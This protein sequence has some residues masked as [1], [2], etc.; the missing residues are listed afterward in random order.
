MKPIQNQTERPG[1]ELLSRAFAG[2]F[3]AFLGL[4]LLKFGNPAVFGNL[5]GW[6]ADV[7]EWVLNP[8]PVVVGYWLLGA[9]AAFG[10]LVARWRRRGPAWLI[11]LPL[12]WLAWQF[13]AGTRTVDAGLTRPV[14]Q[15]FAACVVCYYLGLLSLSRVANP[16]LFW[17]GLLCG[18]LVVLGVGFHQHFGGLEETRKFFY[19]NIYPQLKEISPEYLRKIS[20][21]RIFSTLFYPNVLAGV[22]LLLLPLMLAFVSVNRRM[23]TVPAR[24][25]SATLVGFAALACL[26]W[27][28]SKGGW[29]LML[30]AGLIWLFHLRFSRKLKLVLAGV[31]LVTGLAGFFWRYSTFF[32]RGATSVGARLDYWH[33]A[34]QTAT[35]NPIWGT[36]PG[37]F[38]IAYKKIKRPES[39]MSRLAHNDYL[40]QASDSGFV[41]FLPYSVLITGGLLWIYLKGGLAGNRLGFSVWLGLLGW[42]LQGLVEFGLYIPALAWPA[43]T[44]MGWLLGTTRN[45]IDKEPVGS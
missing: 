15:H 5:I 34:C 20:S 26:Y 11:L 9:V 44:F 25:T 14:L 21:D 1:N 24:W 27:S 6:P 4:S 3:G 31:V 43:F 18:F 37:T 12:V 28:G 40:Q 30:L 19:Q 39:E 22:L 16:V 33:A 10:L 23:L 13:V 17:S 32:Q 7:F 41:G 8:W 35:G 38:A 36:G 45:R 2:L 42:S 29:L